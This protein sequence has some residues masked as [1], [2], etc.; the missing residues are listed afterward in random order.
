VNRIF[1]A[2]AAVV[3]ALPLAWLAGEQHRSNCIEQ[4]RTGCSVLPW[5]GGHHPDSLQRLSPAERRIVQRELDNA[6]R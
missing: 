1:A 2:T 3:V 6:A 4:G 5:T